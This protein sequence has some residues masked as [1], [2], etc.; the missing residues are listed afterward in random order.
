MSDFLVLPIPGLSLL[1]TER[2]A[3]LDVFRLVEQD[4]GVLDQVVDPHGAVGGHTQRPLLVD[5]GAFGQVLSERQVVHGQ[6]ES[7]WW[8]DRKK[9]CAERL[10]R[11][12]NKNKTRFHSGCDVFP[13]GSLMH[14]CMTSDL[15]SSLVC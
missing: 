12:L 14:S 5:G 4:L 10:T 3:A 9:R 13:G 8:T 15:F 1:R 2:L 7:G 6:E 11:H